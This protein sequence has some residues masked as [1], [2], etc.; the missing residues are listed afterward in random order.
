[1]RVERLAHVPAGGRPGVARASR[2][3]RAEYVLGDFAVTRFGRCFG[4]RPDL[5][6]EARVARFDAPPLRI[7]KASSERGQGIAAANCGELL[8]RA[9]IVSFAVR[10]HA[11]RIE[12]EER[13]QPCRARFAPDGGYFVA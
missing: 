2:D 5:F 11:A 1:R 10:T 7:G 3:R 12:D 9:Q 8:A 6:D 13:R 4:P